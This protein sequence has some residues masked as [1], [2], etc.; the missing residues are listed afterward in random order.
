MKSFC[1]FTNKLFATRVRDMLRPYEVSSDV[2][3]GWKH[4]IGTALIFAILLSMVGLTGR[5]NSANRSCGAAVRSDKKIYTISSGF[6]KSLLFK[7][8]AKV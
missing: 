8:Y 5:I 1:A 7:L 6:C 3:T 4:G 2:L